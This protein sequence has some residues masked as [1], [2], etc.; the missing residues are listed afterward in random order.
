[1]AKKKKKASMRGKVK[2]NVERQ[3]SENKGFG[4]VSL[5]KGI[6]F[7]N[8]SMG[9]REYFDIIPYIITDSNHPDRDDENE[10]ALQGDIWY[11][12][13]YRTH[14]NIGADHETVLCLASIGKKCPICE[15]RKKRAD[16]G[17]DKK[18]LQAYN[19]SLRNLYAVIPRDNKDYDEEIHVLDISQFNFQK[20]LN[21][22]IDEDDTY[23]SFAELEGGFTISVRWSEEKMGKNKYAK[24]TSIKFSERDDLD[25]DILEEAPSLDE[26]LKVLS[27]KQLESKFF[28]TED[29]EEEKATRS[30]SIKKRKEKEDDE[31]EEEKPKKPRSSNKK[32]SKK[33]TWDELS[34]MEEEEL[35]EVIESKDLDIDMDDYEDD[36]LNLRIAIA[37][38]LDIELPEEEEEEEEKSVKK[39]SKSKNKCPYGF[40][41]GIDTDTEDECD[42]C[43]LWE[44]CD[45]EK[46][47]SE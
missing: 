42:S 2:K 29:E 37:E 34:D 33:L 23:E 7:Y 19:S 18:E 45:E 8:P 43:R 46:E 47:G 41:F 26:C 10:I 38:E 9:K 32:K 22:E 3:Q 25:E 35:A 13:P 30:S 24:A 15:Y 21:E 20:P 12:R 4:C 36:E 16:E 1:M 28:E 17:A 14:R 6:Q 44:K 11:K 31:D 27:Y 5:P 39:K 40:K